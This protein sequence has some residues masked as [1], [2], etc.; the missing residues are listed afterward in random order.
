MKTV[1]EDLTLTKMQVEMLKIMIEA[2]EKGKDVSIQMGLASGKTT[3]VKIFNEYKS[4][5]KENPNYKIA[6]NSITP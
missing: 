3:I 1:I 5:K 2:Y 6:F 4:H